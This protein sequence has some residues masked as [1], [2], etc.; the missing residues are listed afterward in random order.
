MTLIHL[1][2]LKFCVF[3]HIEHIS[4][5]DG[6]VIAFM[7]FNFMFFSKSYRIDFALGKKILL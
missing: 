4:S 5:L 1:I 2:G 6:Y 7:L 3:S